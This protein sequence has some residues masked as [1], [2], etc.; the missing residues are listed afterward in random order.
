MEMDETTQLEVRTVEI[1]CLM[2][3]SGVTRMDRLRNEAICKRFGMV[4]RVRY[5]NC[6]MGE[7]EYKRWYGQV[8]RM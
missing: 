7:D 8:R 4:E 1:N 6:E 3:G 2:P 5:M